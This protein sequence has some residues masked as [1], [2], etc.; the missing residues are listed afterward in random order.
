MKRIET[1]RLIMR[2]FS[3][4]DA[5]QVYS[6]WASQAEV[7]QYLPWSPHENVQRTKQVIQQWI[8]NEELK[9]RFY[10]CVVL[11]AT[12]ECIGTVYFTDYDPDIKQIETGFCVGNSFKNKGYMSEAIRASSEWMLTA[13]DFDIN[14]II[15]THDIDNGASGKAMEKAGYSFWKEEWKYSLSKNEEVV[16]RFYKLERVELSAK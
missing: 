7:Y 2:P 11:K 10:W 14:Q 1:E 9:Q 15:G 8:E 13:C 5:E 12:N 6:N 4:E 16:T 3:L